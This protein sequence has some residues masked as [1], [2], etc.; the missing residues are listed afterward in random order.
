ME[1]GGLGAQHLD[2]G[3][4]LL[5]PIPAPLGGVVVVGESVVTYFGV[6]QS[7]KSVPT[8]RPTIMKA[9]GRIDVDGSRHLLS[10][11]QVRVPLWHWVYI[12]RFLHND[13]VA[14]M[15]FLMLCLSLLLSVHS[16]PAQF[17]SPTLTTVTSQSLLR[18]PAFLSL[19]LVR[20]DTITLFAFTSQCAGPAVPAGAGT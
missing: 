1:F 12:C 4:S 16:P 15:R 13:R 17:P 5:I 9:A 20:L 14:F 19:C 3:A 8:Q 7:P 10:D 18:S 6:G 2:P 11:H